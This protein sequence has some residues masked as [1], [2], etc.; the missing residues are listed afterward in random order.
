MNH[1]Y[2][3][4]KWWVCTVQRFGPF[5][6]FTWPFTWLATRLASWRKIKLAL[7]HSAQPSSLHARLGTK[8]GRP[9][10]V[11]D[12]DADARIA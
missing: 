1:H 9:T 7:D 12:A 5:S 11:A 4:P 10:R 8:D 2:F 3:H 6:P